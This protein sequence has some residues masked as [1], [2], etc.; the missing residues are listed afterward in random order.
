MTW[1]WWLVTAVL[2]VFFFWPVPVLVYYL[3]Q[4]MPKP[5][6][7]PPDCIPQGYCRG[8]DEHG[9]FGYWRVFTPTS[10]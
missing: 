8:I 10:R 9:R 4:P 1:R 3:L 2:S 6:P 7:T 5:K